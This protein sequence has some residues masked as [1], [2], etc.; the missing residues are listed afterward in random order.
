MYHIACSSVNHVESKCNQLGV[1]KMF[2]RYS[3]HDVYDV[4]WLHAE[5]T[6]NTSSVFK[7]AVCFED[8]W[9]TSFS[10]CG[11]WRIPGNV[12]RA[13]AIQCPWLGFNT[14]RR[15]LLTGT[16]LQNNL[17]E[18][19]GKT[20][21]ASSEGDLDLVYDFLAGNMDVWWL[22]LPSMFK[23]FGHFWVRAGGAGYWA[24]PL[25]LWSLMHFLMPA[26]RLLRCAN[27]QP[28]FAQN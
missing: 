1:G 4:W 28:A 20:C 18:Y 6:K 23:F 15:L 17:T 14:E 25:R 2:M 26:S 22:C 7:M 9:R 21:S 3:T 8:N 12:D 24:G 5:P 16:P 19:L 27:V 11:L 13:S 10:G